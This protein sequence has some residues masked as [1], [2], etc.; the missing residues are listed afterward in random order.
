MEL[1]QEILGVTYTRRKGKLQIIRTEV[2]VVYRSVQ[3]F[4]EK[5]RVA[6]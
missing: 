6:E 1:V 4:V 5:L 2:V 3:G